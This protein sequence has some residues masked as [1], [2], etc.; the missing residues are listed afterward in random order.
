[1]CGGGAQAR[2]YMPNCMMGKLSRQTGRCRTDLPTT[3]HSSLPPKDEYAHTQATHLSS[4]RPPPCRPSPFSFH[5]ILGDI[6]AT[7]ATGPPRAPALLHTILSFFPPQRGAKTNHNLSRWQRRSTCHDEVVLS[8]RLP[9]NASFFRAKGQKKKVLRRAAG[10]TTFFPS[11]DDETV[12]SA[13]AR[14]TQNT[15]PVYQHNITRYSSCT[16]TDVWHRDRPTRE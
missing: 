2:N 8:K 11:R 5:T 4:T 1:M 10:A 7:L 3:K 16:T 9:L 15:Q 6:S 12:H 13:V 14:L